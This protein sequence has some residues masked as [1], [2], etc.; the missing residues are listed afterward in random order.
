MNRL[1]LKFLLISLSLL[2]IGFRFKT[3]VRILY[4]GDNEFLSNLSSLSKKESLIQSWIFNSKTGQLYKYD[5][6][7]NILIPLTREVLDGYEHIY[8]NNY[9]EDN[10]LYF[11]NFYRSLEGFLDDDIY[12]ND[13][14]IG[15]NLIDFKHLTFTYDQIGDEEIYHVN[16]KEIQLPKNIQ[17]LK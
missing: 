15:R 12:D 17:I 1:P 11:D 13:E 4:C 5:D 6:L 14:G 16:C 7:N 9:I 10:K 8:R 3:D 2:S